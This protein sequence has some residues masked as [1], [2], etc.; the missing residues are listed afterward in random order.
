VSQQVPR[1][2]TVRNLQGNMD[3]ASP[4]KGP[5]WSET[6]R[7]LPGREP[8]DLVA[9]QWRMLPTCI[10]MAKFDHR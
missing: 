4:H 1:A 3:D 2:D 7:T 8:G 10:G 9:D 5:V 6:L